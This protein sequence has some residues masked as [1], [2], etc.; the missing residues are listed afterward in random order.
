MKG[1][2]KVKYHNNLEMTWYSEN[3]T[4]N[5]TTDLFK[6]SYLNTLRMVS[7]IEGLQSNR[8]SLKRWDVNQNGFGQS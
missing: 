2:V 3:K 6:L 8:S 1:K 5:N 4:L 7:R